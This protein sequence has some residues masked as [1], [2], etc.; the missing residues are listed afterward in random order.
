MTSKHRVDRLTRVESLQSPTGSRRS[1]LYDIVTDHGPTDLL[2]QFFRKA[3]KII[4]RARLSLSFAPFDELVAINR[5]NRDTWKP[6]VPTFNVESGL[7]D[8]TCAFALV[9]RN[10]QGEPVSAQALRVFDWRTTDF[11]TEAENL[12]LFFADP[13]GMAIRGE[14]CAVTA[15]RA[16]ALTGLVGFSGGA[17]FHPSVRGKLLFAV[18]SR[19]ARAYSYTRW[20]TDLTMAVMSNGL[21][22]KG[23]WRQNGYRHAELGFDLRNFELGNYDGGAVWIIADE[24]IEDLGTFMG[25]MEQALD[26]DRAS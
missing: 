7:L 4:A 18:L 24:L 9:G 17:W 12:R 14:T 3:D 16:G 20:Q 23:F 2:S 8:A 22:E 13:A 21:I 25:E 19:V 5:T 6:I 10:E 11:K 26:G 15:P 1:W